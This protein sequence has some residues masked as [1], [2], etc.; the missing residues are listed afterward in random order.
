MLDNNLSRLTRC[1]TISLVRPSIMRRLDF[2]PR[3]RPQFV[4]THVMQS[5]QQT[6]RAMKNINYVFGFSM[7]HILTAWSVRRV[8]KV[9]LQIQNPTLTYAC[10]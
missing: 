6:N 2:G 7:L 5:G 10:R 9:E 8:S 4:N 3:Q 1:I